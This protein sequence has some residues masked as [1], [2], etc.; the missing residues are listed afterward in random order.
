MLNEYNKAL[1]YKSSQLS[2]L[3]GFRSIFL[4]SSFTLIA[5]IFS[6]SIIDLL[7]YI[8]ILSLIIGLLIILLVVEYKTDVKVRKLEHYCNYIQVWIRENTLNDPKIKKFNQSLSYLPLSFYF[9]KIRDKN[10]SIEKSLNEF[11]K[12]KLDKFIKE[13][14]FSES[15]KDWIL[16]SERLTIFRVIIVSITILIAILISVLSIGQPIS[17]GW[18]DKFTI[19]QLLF[20][21][22]SFS[23][24]SLFYTVPRYKGKDLN[25]SLSFVFI[26]ASIF[27]VLW[28]IISN[29]LLIYLE[30][31]QIDS[32]Q[33]LASDILF[34]LLGEGIVWIFGLQFFKK[35][36]IPWKHYLI[37][38]VLF[39]IFFVTQFIL[40]L[41]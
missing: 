2:R 28:E 15:I 38:I 12:I 30:L 4:G 36:I 37:T 27:L 5:T 31:A 29:T 22:S 32:P 18:I 40:E 1:E 25:L 13:P 17:I 21:I 10:T 8:L 41:F 33:N 35:K 23:L 3:I 19:N 39:M 24:F 20:G 7:V 16:K 9:S 6:L 26:T 14:I 11:N 34:G